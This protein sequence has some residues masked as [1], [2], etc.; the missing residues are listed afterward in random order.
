MLDFLLLGS[1]DSDAF[2]NLCL[3]Y[4]VHLF[5]VD[6][7]VFIAIAPIML[8]WCESFIVNGLFESIWPIRSCDGHS[9]RSCFVSARSCF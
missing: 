8:D 5:V 2:G 4:D 7:V 3:R 1:M 6:I 9:Y